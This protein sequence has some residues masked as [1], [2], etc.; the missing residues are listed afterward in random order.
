MEKVEQLNTQILI[1]ESRLEGLELALQ[2][3][4]ES[5]LK[6]YTRIGGKHPAT[7][8]V[9]ELLRDELEGAVN[10]LQA[11]LK[12]NRVKLA[13]TLEKQRINSPDLPIKHKKGYSF[14]IEKLTTDI[15]DLRLSYIRLE[16][17]FAISRDLKKRGTLRPLYAVPL[18]LALN[19]D[20]R[21]LK[22]AY[23]LITQQCSDDKAKRSKVAQY[24]RNIFN[25]ELG[26]RVPKFSEDNLEKKGIT[27]EAF[28]N[29]IN[30]FP[31]KSSNVRSNIKLLDDLFE[32]ENK[33]SIALRKE[34][35]IEDYYI[36][37]DPEISN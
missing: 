14:N 34:V 27:D 36:Y 25:V 11:R 33:L 24:F 12:K 35:H 29:L 4:N 3:Y 1:L 2:I 30:H 21:N 9:A 10:T 23:L 18:L 13:L 26:S 7:N 32:F 37:T 31:L 20:M 6:V 16:S 28:Y 19:I 8:L 17:E 22:E 5:T 15:T